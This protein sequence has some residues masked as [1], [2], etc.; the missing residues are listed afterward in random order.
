MTKTMTDA[1]HIP[2]YGF[3]DDYDLT[4]LIRIRADLKKSNP[5]LT[6]LPFFIKAISLSLTKF[7]IMN[8]NVNPETDEYGYIKEYVIKADHNISVAID[9]PHGLLVP[10]I[11]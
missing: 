1:L 3:M 11:K 5:K 4:N 9:S 8:I 6:M 2:F 7:P 10:V